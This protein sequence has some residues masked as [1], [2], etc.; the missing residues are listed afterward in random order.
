MC[1]CVKGRGA[2]TQSLFHVSVRLTI[3]VILV[4]VWEGHGVRDI[5]VDTFL[6]TLEGGQCYH[7][8]HGELQSEHAVGHLWGGQH[9]LE[10]Q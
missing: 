6:L 8:V 3:E 7:C 9:C 1:V 5:G 2:A 4:L 10:G